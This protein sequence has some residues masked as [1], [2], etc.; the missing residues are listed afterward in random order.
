MIEYFMWALELL[1]YRT[2]EG[3]EDKN[4][5]M[6]K[7]VWVVADQL[8]I[9]FAIPLLKDVQKEVILLIFFE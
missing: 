2:S 4:I 7:C 3:I 5:S 8:L 1:H 9:Y 6:E